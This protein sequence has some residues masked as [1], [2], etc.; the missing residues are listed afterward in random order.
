MNIFRRIKIN[1]L[2]KKKDR[3]LKESYLYSVKDRKKS[4]ELFVMASEIENKIVEL[5][6]K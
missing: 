2:T 5:N 3:L 1:S 6:N 4:D